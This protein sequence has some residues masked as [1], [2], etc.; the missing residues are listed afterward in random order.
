[1]K[2]AFMEESKMCERCGDMVNPNNPMC[3]VEEIEEPIR[4][5][6]EEYLVIYPDLLEPFEFY[7]VEWKE[8]KWLVWKTAAKLELC[9]ENKMPVLDIN[10]S[11][12]RLGKTEVYESKDGWK[13]AVAKPSI[14]IIS[15]MM[16]EEENEGEC[17]SN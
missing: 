12:L 15:I 6:H 17:Q 8:R 13:F 16:L 7:D 3:T 14:G 4:V 1:M 10:Y 5:M 2:D 9:K 11:L